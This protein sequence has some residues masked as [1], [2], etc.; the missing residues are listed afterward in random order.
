MKKNKTIEN[1]IQSFTKET[2]ILLDTLREM[3]FSEVPEC[4]ELL[5]YGIPSYKYQSKYLVHFAGYEKHIGFYPT[6]AGVK[7]FDTDFKK[8]KTGKGSV[9]FPLEHEIPWELIRRILQF[10]KS[11][12]DN[13]E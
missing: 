1:Y 7:A 11:Q 6:P 4:E 3:I 5:S 13:K 8:Y 9:Q 10:R 2:Q 12:I